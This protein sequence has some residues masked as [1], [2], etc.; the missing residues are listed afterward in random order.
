MTGA[1][2]SSYVGFT[3][4]IGSLCIPALNLE[5]GPAGVGD[6]MTGV[7]QLPAPV[8]AARDL[9]PLGREALR[10][11]DRDRAG[12]QGHARST[13]A[14]RSTSSAT[15]AGGAPSSRSA[16]TRTSTARSARPRSRA[17]SR[18]GRWPRS[19]TSRSTTRRPTGTPRPTTRSSAPRRSRRSTCPAF[20]D[21]VQQGAASSVMCSYCYINGTAA[22][23]NPYLLSH[24]AAAAVRVHRV[25]HLRLGR[26]PLHRRVRQRRPGH[27]HAGQRRV[28]RR[29]AGQ[30]HLQRL[31]AGS[32]P[33]ARSTR[34]SPP[35]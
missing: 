26:H 32:Q 12:G 13:S 24:G 6:G 34:P 4:A 20:Q 16:R 25:R 29:R 11:G 21:A 23:Q 19:S 7:T 2:G 30:R 9:G 1:S 8:D 22:C 27:G 17:S 28:L 3:P 35:S 33:G 14:R 5:D 31:G 18:P 15:R 10:P